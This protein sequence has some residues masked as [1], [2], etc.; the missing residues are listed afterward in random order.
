M[1]ATSREPGRPGGRGSANGRGIPRVDGPGAGRTPLPTGSGRLRTV[2][3]A[4]PQEHP[5]RAG[6][7]G[8]DAGRRRTSAVG[9]GDRRL[10]PRLRRR[11]AG[12][13]DARPAAEL[14]RPG[15]LRH[16]RPRPGPPGR[17]PY[18]PRRR[19]ARYQPA[20]HRLR[21][22]PRPAARRTPRTAV[23]ARADRDPGAA[24][25][26]AQPLLAGGARL[27]RGAGRTGRPARGPR[28]HRGRRPSPAGG[29]GGGIAGTAG[30]ARGRTGGGRYRGGGRR[31][32]G[33]GPGAG[34]GTGGGGGSGSGVS[35]RR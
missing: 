31:R 29:R 24:A 23:R 15:A 11:Q 14:P 5:G 25:D 12:L 8:P 4:G 6:G 19:R 34:E 17:P 10:H 30:G 21:P 26:P 35:G 18:R 28:A 20:A 9:Q 7:T 32:A 3:G 2:A 33:S 13:R 22:A 27:C 16:R 1:Q